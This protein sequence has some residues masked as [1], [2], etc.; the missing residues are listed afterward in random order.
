M[1]SCWSATLHVVN[2]VNGFL[3]DQLFRVLH[4]R[5]STVM[6]LCLHLSVFIYLDI[7]SCRLEYL[8]EERQMDCHGILYIFG[9][10]D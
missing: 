6:Y 7:S 8:N 2:E 5:G 9:L 3:I 10:V 1:L 4:W